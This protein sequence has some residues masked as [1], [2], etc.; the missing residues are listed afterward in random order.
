MVAVQTDN[1]DYS[2]F[3]VIGGEEFEVGNEVSWREDAPLGGH[4]VVNRRTGERADFQNHYV[5]AQQLSQQ[6]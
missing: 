5:S 2:I 3:E 6:L 1:G 4:E